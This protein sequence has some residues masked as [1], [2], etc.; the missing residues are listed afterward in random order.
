MAARSLTPSGATDMALNN[1]DWIILLFGLFNVL[2][3]ASYVPQI[4]TVARDRNGAAAISLTAWSVWLC[5]NAST[6]LY[7]W[8]HVGDIYLAL[9]SAFNAAC[10]MTVLGLTIS[11]R[12]ALA[13]CRQRGAS[14]DREVHCQS[15]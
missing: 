12:A 6:G 7:A 15:S 11:K 9:T 2:R 5:A 1:V 4:A 10:C 13:G 14:P 8:S 3:L